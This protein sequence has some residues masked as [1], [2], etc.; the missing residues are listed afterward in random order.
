MRKKN[1]FFQIPLLT[2][3]LVLCCFIVLAFLP[4]CYETTSLSDYGSYINVGGQVN[5]QAEAYISRFF[6]AS[7]S[8]QFQKIR[9]SYRSCT[10][11]SVAFEAFLEFTIED[12]E[13]FRAYTDSVTSAMVP[14]EF[15]FDRAYKQYVLSDP[16]TGS[17]QDS[18]KLGK[19]YTDYQGDTHYYID[20]AS[21]AKIL[22]NEE[23]HRIIF[24]A[25][26]LYDGGGT[27]TSFLNAFFTRFHINPA[28][29]E[30]RTNMAGIKTA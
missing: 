21:I 7:L 16:Q 15:R 6:P 30:S 14:E 18:L 4:V 1:I 12:A 8:A 2:L 11:D 28:E 24:V 3:L 17:L 27:G 26:Q 20:S 13:E 25:M 5:S 19:S 9:Y 22:V 10:A 29:Y 23:E